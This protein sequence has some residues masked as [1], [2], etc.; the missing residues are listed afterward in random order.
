MAD[1]ENGPNYSFL[2]DFMATEEDPSLGQIFFRAVN[3][4]CGLSVPYHTVF[5]VTFIG[6]VI[7]LPFKFIT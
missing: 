1:I 6:T 5:V 3:I 2:P 4:F 7:T